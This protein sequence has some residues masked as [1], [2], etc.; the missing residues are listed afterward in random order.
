[1]LAAMLEGHD[2]I[3]VA[4][5]VTIYVAR[6]V[7]DARSVAGG[8]ER[9]ARPRTRRDRSIKLD[10]HGVFGEEDKGVNQRTRPGW[11]DSHREVPGANC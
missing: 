7:P 11:H 8:N 2:I 6:K 5:A 4:D 3:G 10:P 9:D 1:M